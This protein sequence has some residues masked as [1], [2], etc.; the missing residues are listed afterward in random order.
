MSVTGAIGLPTV[1]TTVHL[2]FTTYCSHW[3]RRVLHACFG[4]RGLYRRTY[5]MRPHSSRAPCSRR[6]DACWTASK[7]AAA[8]S[9]SDGDSGRK[10]TW[11]RCGPRSLVLGGGVGAWHCPSDWRAGNAL[12]ESPQWI[13]AL[14]RRAAS[15][16]RCHAC[17][18]RHRRHCRAGVAGS[19]GR[20]RWRWRACVNKVQPQVCQWYLW[21]VSSSERDGSGGS[22][23]SLAVHRVTDVHRH[24]RGARGRVCGAAKCSTAS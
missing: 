21:G 14:G 13:V 24:R 15:R 2:L 20:V 9:A 19:R 23:A 11:R 17:A 4:R 3:L 18:I 7:S 22:S 16:G 5:M 6:R 12:D 8:R 10:V 1:H